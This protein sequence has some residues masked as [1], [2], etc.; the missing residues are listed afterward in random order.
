MAL[1][2]FTLH[3]DYGLVRKIRYQTIIKPLG[4]KKE[5]RISKTPSSSDGQNI[6]RVVMKER[7]VSEMKTGLYDFYT[8]RRGSFEKFEVEDPF[9]TSVPKARLTVRF[10]EDELEETMFYYLLESSQLELIE[11]D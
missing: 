3:S 10:A 9:S 7:L 5:Q 4:P 8:A 6:L 2:L 1:E 11:V